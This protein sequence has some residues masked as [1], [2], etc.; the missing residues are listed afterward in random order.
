M[1]TEPTW[2]SWGEPFKRDGQTSWFVEAVCW[3]GARVVTRLLKSKVPR[4]LSCRPCLYK[5]KTKH[6]HSGFRRPSKTYTCWQSMLDR[7]ENTRCQWFPNYGGR[8][9][10]VCERWQKFE[11]FLADMGERPPG[12]TID[13]VDNSAG[14]FP[15]N[16]RW[17]T[18][19]EQNRNTRQNIVLTHNGETMVAS[20]WA[21]RLGC[22][23]AALRFRIRRG[24]STE[25]A[26]T[27]P[28]DDAMGVR[29]RGGH[30][31]EATHDGLTLTLGE[32][33]DRIGVKRTTLSMRLRAGWS[34]EKALTTAA[35]SPR[36]P[37]GPYRK[38][39]A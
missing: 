35:N 12:L 10:T 5:R 25:R 15:E 20:A 9:I 17:A 6:G 23:P 26:L 30:Y 28:F 13:R 19:T 33:A 7:C 4:A 24:W 3:C 31:E 27:E 37:R 39:A 1:K 36:G 32:W 38:R 29:R 11:N 34:V 16:C 21:E 18:K 8:G 14:Y 22:K 2:T